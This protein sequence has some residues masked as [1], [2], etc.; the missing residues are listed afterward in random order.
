[1]CNQI[2]YLKKWIVFKAAQREFKLNQYKSLLVLLNLKSKIRLRNVLTTQCLITP[3]KSEWHQLYKFGSDENLISALSL[4]RYGFSK[5]LTV[6]SKFYTVLSGPGRK[7][8]T[9]KLVDKS[10][11][12]G[13][14]LTWYSDTLSYKSICRLFGMPPA[15]V[16]RYVTKSE[17]A[18]LKAVRSINE[19]KICWPSK[20]DQ[21]RM[22]KLVE[23]KHPLIKGRW[24]FIDGKNLPVQKP[25]A[26]DLQNA[27]YNGWLHST[28]ITGCIAFT[29]N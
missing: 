1:M 12:L 8:R 20:A 21:I 23:K 16:S 6:F 29:V 17:I 7:G 15:T 25:T 14:I 5:L 24:C 4:N 2:K 10:M 13:M 3:D 26:V 9:P 19:A 18:L 22:G 28:L 11:I 27:M